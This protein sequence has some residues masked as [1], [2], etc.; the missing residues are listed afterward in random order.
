MDLEQA[1]KTHGEWK[2]KFRAAI[3][4]K[5]QMDVDAITA[6]NCCAL[7]KWLHGEGKSRYANLASYA[8][9]V[10]KHAEFHHQAGRIAKTINHGHFPEAEAMLGAGTFYSAASS[11]VGVAILALKKDARL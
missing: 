6:D 3:S 5:E 10:G 7:G 1:I 8:N 9:C 11:A 2:L 4:G